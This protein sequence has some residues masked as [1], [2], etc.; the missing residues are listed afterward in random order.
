[1]AARLSYSVTEP[2]ARAALGDV[3]PAQ[4]GGGGRFVVRVERYACQP[5]DD[6]NAK[7][8][9]KALVDLLRL[10][11]IIPDDDLESIKLEVVQTKVA[12]KDEEGT[13]VKVWSPPGMTKSE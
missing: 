5:L 2:V 9:A 11:Q 6:D 12:H 8:G 4:E 7:G 3:L 10:G 13:W 1:M